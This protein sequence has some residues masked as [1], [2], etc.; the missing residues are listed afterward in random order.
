MLGSTEAL[1]EREEPDRGDHRP[2]PVPSLS[3]ELAD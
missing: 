3:L 1:V 2:Q